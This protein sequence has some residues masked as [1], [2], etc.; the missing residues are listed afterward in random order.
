MRSTQTTWLMRLGRSMEAAGAP[1]QRRAV[2]LAWVGV[3]VVALLAAGAMAHWLLAPPQTP[4]VVQRLPG[5][6]HAPDPGARGISTLLV[7]TTDLRG[8]FSAGQGTA[9]TTITSAWPLFRGSNHD[10][11]STEQVPLVR[12]L[13]AGTL[14]NLWTVE[15]GQGYGGPAVRDGRVYVLDHDKT[16]FDENELGVLLIA[17]AALFGFQPESTGAW[18]LALASAAH[19]GGG[20]GADVLRCLSLDDGREI[21]RRAYSVNVAPNHGITRTVPAVTQK[22]VVSL[23]PKC[24]VICCDAITGEFVWGLDLVNQYRSKW[25]A[26]YAGQCPLIDGDRVIIAPGGDALMIAVELS[27]GKVLWTTP[28]PR[29]WE[30]THA[31]IVPM[32]FAGRRMYL[33]AGNRGVVGVS[34]EDGSVLWE[35]D[36]GV[37]RGKRGAIP[38]ESTY[39]QVSTATVPTP[40]PC[41]DGRMFLCGGYG[42]GSMMLQLTEQNGQ[43]VPKCL[44]RLPSRVFGSEQQTPVFYDG[45]LYGVRSDDSRLVCLDLNGRERWNSGN[46]RFDKA[47][48]PYLIADGML[49]L[50]NVDSTLT[51][52]EVS[53]A[54]YRPLGSAQIW[55]D[56]H[57]TW[58]PLALVSGRLLVRDL[59]RMTMIDLR[60]E[61]P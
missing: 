5:A 52:A 36:P 48:G 42:A 43:I 44:F 21:W 13:S 25:P 9:S 30:M 51:L 53:P 34:A 50:V 11:I 39:W 27:T 7:P 14:K 38:P 59:D 29:K 15:M 22:Y 56:G 28:N 23:G 2:A 6:D 55:E 20:N 57:E 10:G 58:A 45:F 46:A 1:L 32:T 26:W 61:Q 24:H 54:S 8:R 47:Y 16:A 41:G 33:Y 35:T 4:G 31:S 49:I 17:R 60:K 3:A 18:P 12:T 40:V 19:P 37:K